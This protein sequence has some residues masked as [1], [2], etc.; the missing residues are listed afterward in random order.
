MP[1]GPHGLP[2]R[3]PFADEA[4]PPRGVPGQLR[5]PSVCSGAQGRAGGGRRRRPLQCVRRGRLRHRRSCARHRGVQHGRVGRPHN[6]GSRG[7][8]TVRGRLAE[9]PRLRAGL[10]IRPAGE[11]GRRVRSEDRRSGGGGEPEQGRRDG[12][13][14][15]FAAGWH[16]QVPEV[17][18]R[19]RRV[20]PQP[21]ELRCVAA[22]LVVESNKPM[23]N[24]YSLEKKNSQSISLHDFWLGFPSSSEMVSVRLIG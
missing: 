11:G 16:G 22:Q 12:G 18:R 4:S 15:L 24:L 20:G 13:G 5:R 6:G 21:S 7:G 1:D 3:P 23:A 9:V 17:H 10:R 19:C 14:R 2:C 8:R